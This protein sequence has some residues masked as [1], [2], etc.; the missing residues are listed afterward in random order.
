MKRVMPSTILPPAPAPE[1]NGC[2]RPPGAAWN[3]FVLPSVPSADWPASLHFEQ[4]L[5]RLVRDAL[6]TGRSIQEI[7]FGVSA[8]AKSLALP[9]SEC[10]LT[11]RVKAT[12]LANS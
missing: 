9:L 6:A 8:L 1:R 10:E 5:D 2:I 12:V 7:T 3:G 11:R 4:G